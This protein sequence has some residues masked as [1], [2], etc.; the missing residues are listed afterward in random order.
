MDMPKP[1]DAHKKLEVLIG[2]WSGRETLHPS[3]WDPA[4]GTASATVTNRWIADGFAVVQDYQQ[5]RGG[6][7][8]FSGHGV[9]WFDPA[10]QE[11]VMHW[12]DSM[13]G[14]G[15][16]YRGQ[17]TGGLLMLGAPMPQGGQS[18]T[19]WNITGPGSHTFLMEVSQDGEN[20]MPAMEGRYGRR[21][22]KKT[23]AMK[24]RTALKKAAPK[25][26]A[27]KKVA[28]RQPVKKAAK[29]ATKKATAKKAGKKPAKKATRR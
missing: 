9:F 20:W 10:K 23:S 5:R 7:V 12:W 27:L 13:G 8:T 11:Y 2:D 16:E 4:G 3:P 17:F 24:K 28:A 6:K 18:R 1:G 15:G 22:A 21:A 19:T 26:A 29:K 14:T 25:K